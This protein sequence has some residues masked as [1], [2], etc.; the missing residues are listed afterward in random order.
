MTNAKPDDPVP[1]IIGEALCATP[2]ETQALGAR[3][4][5]A[6]EAG[7]V[8]SLEGPLGAGKTQFAKGFAEA[9][10]HTGEVSSPTFTLVHEYAGGRWPVVHFDWYRLE[11]ATEVTGLGWDDYL[12]GGETLLIEWGDRFPELLPADAWRLRFAVAG[13]GRSIQWERGA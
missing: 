13:D 10:G 11:E 2:E 12:D 5:R 3:F 7:A 9:L 4:G 1:E 6:L 8:L